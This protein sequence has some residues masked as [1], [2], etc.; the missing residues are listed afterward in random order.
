MLILPTSTPV[1]IFMWTYFNPS[2]HT[3]CETKFLIQN[4]TF[5]CLLKNLFHEFSFYFMHWSSTVAVCFICESVKWHYVHQYRNLASE[6]TNSETHFRKKKIRNSIKIFWQ[7]RSAFGKNWELKKAQ[8]KRL[9]LCY[10][11]HVWREG[12]KDIEQFQRT[13]S[14]GITGV[15]KTRGGVVANPTRLLVHWTWNFDNRFK[16]CKVLSRLWKGS[17]KNDRRNL[18]RH[19][20]TTAA[21]FLN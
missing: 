19:S 3:S 15:M 13:A 6:E 9:V 20:S 18:R 11:C 14:I 21:L 1:H 4:L 10:E 12:K 5:S 17:D 16:K 2:I 8:R 7:C